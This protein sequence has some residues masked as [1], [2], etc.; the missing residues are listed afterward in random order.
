MPTATDEYRS[1]LQATASTV[2]FLEIPRRRYLMVDG[3]A[4]PGE[5]EFRDAIACLYPVAYTLHFALKRKG[6]DAPVGA[7]EGLYAVGDEAPAWRLLLP[8]PEAAGDSDVKAAIEEVRA[9]KHPALIDRLRCEAWEEG[10]VAQTLHVGPYDAETAT[11][12]R[13]RAA[14]AERGLE[15]RGWHHEI[16]ISDPNRTAPARLKT[17]LRQPVA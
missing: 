13:V 12:D 17:L 11:V 4:R 10:A 1:E 7:L 5:Q 15:P 2:R 8:V 14:I 6:V 9:K 16:Y 3:T